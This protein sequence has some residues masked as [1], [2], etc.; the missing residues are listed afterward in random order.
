MTWAKELFIVVAIVFLGVSLTSAFRDDTPSEGEILDRTQQEKQMVLNQLVEGKI[1]YLKSE[2]YKKFDPSKIS[3]PDA[4]F[5]GPEHRQGETWMGADANGNTS[6]QIGVSRTLQ[7]ELL[8]VSKW[9]EGRMVSTW[10]PT[11]EEMT[12]ETGSGSSLL[13]WVEGIWRYRQRYTDRGWTYVGQGELNGERSV[14]LE[15]QYATTKEFSPEGLEYIGTPVYASTVSQERV[16]RIEFVVVTP[17]IWWSS[18]WEL[19]EAGERTLLGEHRVIEYQ[20]L[21][22]DTQIGPFQ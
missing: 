16:N 9:E 18:L 14:I 2:A 19:S 7:G 21:P 1:L 13:G 3:N 11:G 4:A 10:I 5:V 17:L 15:N 12:V 6:F 22:A 8:A 20:M